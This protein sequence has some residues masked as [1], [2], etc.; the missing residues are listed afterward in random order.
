MNL[1]FDQSSGG[2]ATGGE[3]GDFE[4][5]IGGEEEGTQYIQITVEEEAAINRVSNSFFLFFYSFVIQYLLSFNSSTLL[6][7]NS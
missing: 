2:G 3:G 5:H 7:C 4:E 6:I 1:L